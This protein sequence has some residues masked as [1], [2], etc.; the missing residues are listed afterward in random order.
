[1]E[2]NKPEGNRMWKTVWCR[3]FQAVLKIGNYFMGYRTPAT[4]EGPGKVREVGALLKERGLNDIL[5]VT[6]ASGHGAASA[7]R[8]GRSGSSLYGAD[9]CASRPHR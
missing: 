9:L 5:V 6:G 7:G 2:K 8:T 4:L 3:S 1:M